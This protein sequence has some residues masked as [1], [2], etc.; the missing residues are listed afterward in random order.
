METFYQLQTINNCPITNSWMQKALHRI[1]T[2]LR[3]V[4]PGFAKSCRVIESKSALIK[5]R[6][7]NKPIGCNEL[8]RSSRASDLYLD[9]R[10]KSV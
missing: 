8:I 4:I 2:D 9:H 5:C 1:S 3:G 10:D 7:M 6:F